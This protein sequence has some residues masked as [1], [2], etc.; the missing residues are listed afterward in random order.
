[1]YTDME[2]WGEI[3]RRVLVEGEAKRRIQREFRIHWKTLRKILTHEEPPGYRRSKPREKTKI[4]PFVGVVEEIL[5]ADKEV[6]P[7]QRHTAK[8]IFDRL[9]KEHGYGGGYT[10]VKDLVCALRLK[11]HEVFVPLVHRPGEAQVDFGRAYVTLDGEKTQVALF[12]M[13]LPY[14]DAEFACVFPRECPEAFLE[15]HVRAF[16]FF[17]GVARR[18]IYDNTSSAVSKIT[19]KR[20]R[21][22]TREFLRLKSH[23]LFDVHFC[24]VRRPNEKGVVENE[25]GRTRRNYLVPVPVV[26]DLED[27]NADLRQACAEDLTRRVRGFEKTKGELLEEERKSLLPLPKQRFEGRRIETT[28]V[29]SLSLARFD[30]NDYSVPTEYAHHPV[31]AVGGISEV[32]FVVNDRL[33]ARHRRCWKKEMTFFE[34]VHYLAL[35]ERKPGAL[36]FARPLSGMTLPGGFDVLRRRLESELGAVGTREFI[37][38]LRLLERATPTQ[39]S[40]AVD[41]ALSIGATSSDAVRLILE[42]RSERPAGLFCLEGRPRLKEVSVAAP[43]LKA[44][45]ALVAGG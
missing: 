27:L 33:V 8:R 21:E 44:Y 19:G 13:V 37:K 38:V 29:S 4:G 5:K 24:L 15:G 16:E 35:L 43:D 9:R 39:L 2:M 23:Y 45:R 34:P 12:V 30:C 17:G 22:L 10:A 25:I 7:K 41:H 14:S 32:R 42:Q 28:T 40:D 36:D 1:M 11:S 26:R 31:T 20:T 3:R 6:H 18:M